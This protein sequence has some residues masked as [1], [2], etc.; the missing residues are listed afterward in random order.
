MRRPFPIKIAPFAWGSGPHPIR[1]SLQPHLSPRPKR[2]LDRIS[3]FCRDHYRDRQTDVNNRPHLRT[4]S[5]GL[6]RLLT[7]YLML[8]KPK[9]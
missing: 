8:Y 4:Y 1:Y 2:H 3:R 7:V 6:L 9:L 5:I